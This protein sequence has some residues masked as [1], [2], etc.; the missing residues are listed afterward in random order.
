MPTTA[1]TTHHRRGEVLREVIRVAD[2]RRDG[3]LPMDVAGV[4]ETFA[5]EATLLGALQL[6]W[7]TRL[8]G[9]IER[10][11]ALQPMDLD[12]AIVRAW[13]ATARQMPGVRA[14]LDH[15]RLEPGSD[16]AAQVLAKSTGKEHEMLAVMAGRSSLGDPL[17]AGVGERIAD[18]ARA[19][20]ASHRP[21]RRHAAP[22]LVERLR[23]VLA[24]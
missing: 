23:A 5:D 11:L 13:V 16:E 18:R 2:E 1:W 7:H 10:E 14:L 9:R 20:Y 22:T 15:H 12:A 24:A 21:A 8:S 19:A 6:R 17:A 3:L 4:A